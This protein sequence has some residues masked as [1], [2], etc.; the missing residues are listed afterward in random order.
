MR[1]PLQAPDDYFALPRIE[2][3]S[4]M[5]EDGPADF[6][7]PQPAV[8]TRVPGQR[9]PKL[10][11]L[12][13]DDTIGGDERGGTTRQ[14]PAQKQR[15]ENAAAAAPSDHLTASHGGVGGRVGMS[16]EDAPASVPPASASEAPKA[17]TRAGEVSQAR[18]AA[19]VRRGPLPSV[20]APTDAPPTLK[21]IAGA[22]R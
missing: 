14:T 7:P 13:I 19:S 18:Q 1:D 4:R 21:M 17:G 2:T 5:A 22:A 11:E 3:A 16:A 8:S 9:A 15:G 10:S 6:E 12:A 20:R